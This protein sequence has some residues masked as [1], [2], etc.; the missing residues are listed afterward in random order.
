MSRTLIFALA[1]SAAAGAAPAF[2]Q[3]GEPLGG[4]A[5]PGICLISQQA[6]LVNAKVGV[7]VTARLQQLVATAQ[8]EVDKERAPIDASIKAFQAGQAKMTP[9]AAQ[10]EQA[11]LQARLQAIQAKADGRSRQIE[12]TRAKALQ[13]VDQDAQP[14]IAQ[15]YKA[16]GCGL[17]VDRNVVL[18]GN[19]SGDITADVVKGLDA[20]VQTIAFD[21]E[22]ASPAK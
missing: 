1:V 20:K 12:A 2:A 4:P 13:R 6:V 5:I 8:A 9:A 17:L 19:M 3:T 22:P 15:V 14:V 7:A 10:K 18:G 16:H 21:L 11:S